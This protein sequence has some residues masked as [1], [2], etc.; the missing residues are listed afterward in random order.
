MSQPSVDGG[1]DHVLRALRDG[2]RVHP[3][4][5]APLAL[6][7]VWTV[8]LLGCAVPAVGVFGIPKLLAGRP[9]ERLLWTP[10]LI[11]VSALIFLDLTVLW[12]ARLSEALQLSP[13]RLVHWDWRGRRREVAWHE[14]DAVSRGW[15]FLWRLPYKDALTVYCDPHSPSGDDFFQIEIIFPPW[16]YRV[17]EALQDQI[18]AQAGLKLAESDRFLGTTTWE[19]PDSES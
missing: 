13:D 17:I 5:L 14:I 7:V 16:P 9:S 11:V 8:L 12:S 15:D 4:G 18:I 19:R 3:S 10:L 6:L 2:E 1:A